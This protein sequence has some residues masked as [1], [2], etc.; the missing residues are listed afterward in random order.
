MKKLTTVLVLLALVVSAGITIWWFFIASFGDRQL[1]VFLANAAKN[2]TV[3]TISERER[4]GFPFKVRWRLRGV[5]VSHR[6]GEGVLEGQIPEV[7]AETGVFEPQR[8]L[9]AVRSMQ[10]WRWSPADGSPARVYTAQSSAGMVGPN[11]AASGWRAEAALNQIAWTSGGDGRNGSAERATLE[12]IVPLDRSSV[13]FDVGMSAIELPDE[14]VFGRTVEKALIAGR[15]DPLPRDLSPDGL[16]NW[17]KSGGTVTISRSSLVYGALD[18]GAEGEVSLGPDMRPEG[19]FN[20]TV[21]DPQS[22]LDIALR[23]GWVRPD[24]QRY[25]ELGMTLFSRSNA[26]GQ[27]ELAARLDLREGGLWMGPLRLAELEPLVPVR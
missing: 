3:V 13:T 23:E 11:E 16:I 8:T 26:A 17:Q 22:L 24:Q 2:G 4:S 25:A 1:E 10:K 20:L 14:L 19:Q 15:V 9:F 5:A 21:L 18:G 12:A 6:S 27:R 7:L